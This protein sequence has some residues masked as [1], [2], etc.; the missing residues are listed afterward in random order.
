MLFALRRDCVRSFR[1]L[2]SFVEDSRLPAARNNSHGIE[3]ERGWQGRVIIQ[4]TG[5]RVSPINL[6]QLPLRYVD[7]VE[8]RDG[9]FS[10]NN[11]MC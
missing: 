11:E 6:S 7:V 1:F 8:K 9:S 10:G 3:W 2:S 5:R 4:C